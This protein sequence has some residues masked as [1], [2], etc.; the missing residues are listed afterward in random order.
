[1]IR[2]RKPPI[3]PPCEYA[4]AAASSRRR[5]ASIWRYSGAS[6]S[7]VVATS[8]TGSS[9]STRTESGVVMEAVTTARPYP[10]RGGHATCPCD[11]VVQHAS[12]Q[13]CIPRRTICLA[14]PVRSLEQIELGMRGRGVDRRDVTG[15]ALAA[16][17]DRPVALGELVDG[18]QTF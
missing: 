16:E 7:T 2:W 13:R 14:C 12:D 1:M 17:L 9:G 8:S 11:L 4:L 10:K 3:L 18:E 15:A 5:I 6:S